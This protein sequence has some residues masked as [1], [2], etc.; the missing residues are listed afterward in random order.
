MRAL[1][2]PA[3]ALWIVLG[4]QLFPPDQ[5]PV[6]AGTPAFMA[7]DFELCVR[8]RHHQQK[9][10]LFLAAMRN[11]RDMLVTHGREVEYRELAR[12]AV[13]AAEPS[14]EDTLLEVCR[15]RHTT[16]LVHF[17]IDDRFFEER[18]AAFASRHGLNRR[19]M[20]TPK[21]LCGAD[22]LAAY[23]GRV[24]QPRLADF[25]R[26]QRRRLGLLVD[27]RGKPSGGR[28][29]HD[30]DNRRRLP[31]G[32]TLPTPTAYSAASHVAAVRNL[33]R[34]RFGD[35]PG[36]TET[37]AWPTTRAEALRGLDEFLERRLAHFGPYEDAIT[38]RSAT[39][40]HSLLSPA[41]N[42]GL[43]TPREVVQRVMNH[44]AT[45]DIPLNSLEGF[46]RQIIGW[47]EFVRGVYRQHGARQHTVNFFGHERLLT[48]HWYDGTTGL[49]PLDDAIR[50]AV[51]LGWT[52]HIVRLMVVANVM[53]LAEIAPP[54]AYRWFMELYVDSADWVMGPNVYGMGIFSD[55]G[56]FATKPYLCA[57]S[58]LL[59]MSD[60]GR[61]EWCDV[62]D[63]LYWRFVAKHKEFFSAQPRL[64]VMA[65]GLE[66][67]SAD[68]KA[69]IFAAAETFL[70]RCTRTPS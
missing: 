59:K 8:V 65:G 45:H 16:T 13:A 39:I 43:I 52:H 53:T 21:F 47:R 25:Y 10:V 31:R 4:D 42:L 49:V 2:L 61:G 50:T 20:P 18:L 37:F 33:V 48:T 12:E 58:Y 41:L 34:D 63:G 7:E 32:V 22:E 40:F 30:A 3:D 46:V 57:S 27:A 55:G 17:E 26:R 60:Y 68:R 66:R 64:S 15:R 6:P 19:V 35:H 69:R 23:F 14:Y 5:V 29:S 62:L 51:R 1:P 44:A 67:L 54:E 24:R 11:Y 9:L 38:T 36:S 56:V 70:A 28:W